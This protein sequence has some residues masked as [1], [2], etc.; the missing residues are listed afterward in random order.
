MTDTTNTVDAAEIDADTEVTA[1]QQPGILEHRNPHSLQIGE[2][3]RDAVDLGREFLASLREHGVLVPLTAVRGDDG[4]V[5]VRNGQRR[6]LGAREV[7][8]TSVP[9]YVLPANA[10][11][12][13]DEAVERIV[14]QIVTNDQKDDLTDAQRARG[15]QQMIDAG[16]NATKVAKRLSVSRDTVKAATTAAESAAAMDALNCGQLSLV[17]AA[18]LTEFD[19]A[20]PDVLQQ[21]LDAAGGPQFDH[22]VAQLRQQRETEQAREQAAESYRAQGYQVI[23]EQPAWRDTS[24]VELRW[25]RTAEGDTVTEDAITNPTHWAVWLDEEIAFIDS[26]TGERV[27][28]DAIDFATEDD[29]NA[30]AEEGLRHFSTVTEKTVFTAEWYCTDYQGAGLELD[31]FLKNTRPIVHGQD[32]TAG[33]E[34]GNEAEARARREAEEAEAAKRERRK[35][36]ALNKLG[37]AAASVRR[38]FVRK[39]LA[40][41]TPPKGAAV[42]VAECLARDKFLLDQHHGDETAAE[43][44]GLDNSA[45]VR[46]LVES[47]GTGGDAR[48]QVIVLGLV[49]GSM[50]ARTPKDAW[51]NASS[52]WLTSGVKSGEYL[53]FLAEQGYTLSAVEEVITADRTADSVYDDQGAAAG[54]E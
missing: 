51:R 18:A 53:K 17:E 50:E 41:K 36:L 14:H 15:I 31:A 38:E 1:E 39:L 10:S 37:D 20:G 5:T 30:E 12:D 21:L 49:L 16:L 40:R 13:T 19:D 4:V 9:V 29:P 6:T 25:L 45:A 47:L 44:L 26:E 7:G 52:G 27:D 32:E 48:A 42:F 33:G 23:D 43:L 34:S 24:C 2:N 3:I 8:L 22:T 46:K 35:V 54:K 11:D 28:E